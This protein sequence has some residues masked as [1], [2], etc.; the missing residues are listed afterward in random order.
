MRLVTFVESGTAR[1]GALIE[2]DSKVVDLD[3]GDML[4]LLAASDNRFDTALSKVAAAARTYPLDKVT[5]LAP[6]PRPPKI[7]CVG[8]NYRDH[9]LEGGNPIPEH[10]VL[11]SKYPVSVIGPGETIRLPKVST[12]VDYEGEFAV[13]IG[14]RAKHVAKA[15]ALDVVAGYTVMNDV[16]ARDWQKRTSQWMVGKAFDTFA[17]MGPALVTKDEVPDPHALSIRTYVNGELRQDSNTR[18][19]IFG[20]DDLIAEISQI[21]TL[22]PGDVILTGT[23]SGVGAYWDPPKLLKAGDRVRIEIEKVGVLENPVADES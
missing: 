23:P 17:P 8:L 19:L 3:A 4:S 20:V 5:L 6:V 16:S 12:R 18:E 21:W 10:P 22:E 14:K 13:V 9:A 11:F 2:N 15:D 1:A 7:T